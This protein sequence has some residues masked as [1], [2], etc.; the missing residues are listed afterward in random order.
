MVKVSDLLQMRK[1]KVQQQIH[2]L[3]FLMVMNS[4]SS[5]RKITWK[6]NPRWWDE[7][8]IRSPGETTIFC[9]LIHASGKN[10]TTSFERQA[11][12]LPGADIFLW[13]MISKLCWLWA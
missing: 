13:K 5:M 1:E 4:T 2:K 11:I 12:H 10:A 3:C 6:T 7:A 9:Q 8:E